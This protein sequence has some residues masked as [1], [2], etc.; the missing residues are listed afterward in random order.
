MA[1]RLAQIKGKMA[2]LQQEQDKIR[3][4]FCQ[5]LSQYLIEAEAFEVD[6]D[7]LIGGVIEVIANLKAEVVKPAIDWKEMQDLSRQ[8]FPILLIPLR[9]R[10]TLLSS[11]SVEWLGLFFGH[12]R[13][14]VQ[15]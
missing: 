11:N 12:G 5:G 6:F 7:I 3:Q 10:P 15:T 2:T 9:D 13:E 4:N 14:F 8:F 1:Y